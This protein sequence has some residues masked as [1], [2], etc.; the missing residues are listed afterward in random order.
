[1]CREKV[2]CL[3]TSQ[4]K[5]KHTVQY[6]YTSTVGRV[7]DVLSLLECEDFCSLS[8]STAYLLHLWAK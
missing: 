1:M 6:I 3:F 5:K 7:Y 8:F 4:A 2:Y